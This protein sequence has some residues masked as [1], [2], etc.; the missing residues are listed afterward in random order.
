MTAAPAGRTAVAKAFWRAA[1]RLAVLFG[2]VFYGLD[3]FTA[4][5][6]AR[7]P[8]HF[9]WE[10]AIPYWPPAYVAYFSVLAVPLLVP[11]LAQDAQSVR[12]WERRMA[13]AVLVAGGVFLA[14]PSQPGYAPQ[15][16]GAWSAWAQLAQA[17]AGRHNMLPSLHVG[18]SLLTLRC[19]WP[20]ASRGLRQL[21]G[22]WWLAMTASVLLT[23]QHHV[24]DV[25]AGIALAWVLTAFSGST[26]S[27]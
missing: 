1:W 5:R 24:A 2:I 10:L 26:R 19:I 27:S 23:H 8:I 25:G 16:A 17:V 15:D 4:W 12:Q 3:A 14:L 6:S 22:V 18:L 13:L 21:L 11:W 20:G 9:A 7:V